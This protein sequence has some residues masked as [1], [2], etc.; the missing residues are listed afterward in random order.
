MVVLVVVEKTATT[1]T[2]TQQQLQQREGNTRT[3]RIR[4]NNTSNKQQQQTQQQPYQQ[5]KNNNSNTHKTAT[6]TRQQQQQQPLPWP[7]LSAAEGVYFL[8]GCQRRPAKKYGTKT[9]LK[10]H[11]PKTAQLP[12]LSRLRCPRANYHNHVFE[13]KIGHQVGSN[14]AHATLRTG[15]HSSNDCTMTVG[16]PDWNP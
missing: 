4:Q 5:H 12:L 6:T 9:A 3:T 7:F 2:T 8:A 16:I 15:R 14:A 1:L 10:K 13:P 11:A